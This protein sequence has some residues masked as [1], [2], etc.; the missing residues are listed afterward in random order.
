[1]CFAWP[2]NFGYLL[3]LIP[4]VVLF[5][6]GFMRRVAAQELLSVGRT[7][8]GR[9]RR[10]Q[11]ARLVLQFAG[12]ALLLFALT[13]PRFCHGTRMA[14]RKSA[15]VVFMLD[16]SNSMLAGDVFPSRLERSKQAALEISGRLPES[17]QALLLFAARPL[18][19]CPLTTDRE[20]FEALV[21]MASPALV[22]EQGTAFGKAFDQAAKLFAGAQRSAGSPETAGERIIVLLSDGEDHEGGAEEAAR[23]LGR[24]GIRLFVLGVGRAG[25]AVVPDFRRPGE[26]KRDAGGGVVKSRFNP[27]TLRGLAE[28]SGGTYIDIAEGN[29]KGDDVARRISSIVAASRPVAV[30]V[31]GFPLYR[32]LL[33]AGLLLLLAERLADGVGRRMVR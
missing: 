6:Y 31:E 19:Q 11:L 13:G 18:V 27:E 25:E 30:Q 10:R 9:H 20:I 8:G 1:M 23:Q 28:T 29:A 7:D 16:V 15:D 21:D 17:R 5:G 22:D 4:L 24:S 3:L 2:D 33:G 32:Y 12:I 26:A 14:L